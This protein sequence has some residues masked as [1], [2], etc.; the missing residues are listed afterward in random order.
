MLSQRFDNTLNTQSSPEIRANR[1]RI[2]SKEIFMGVIA[3]GLAVVGSTAISLYNRG[4]RTQSPPIGGWEDL[5]LTDTK[6]VNV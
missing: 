4:M 5:D 6:D 1:R 2:H 3:V